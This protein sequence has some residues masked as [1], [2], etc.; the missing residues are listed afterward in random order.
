MSLWEATFLYLVRSKHS[1]VSLKIVV[2]S[3]HCR[4][5]GSYC[6]DYEFNFHNFARQ[7]PLKFVIRL[8]ITYMQQTKIT[9]LSNPSLELVV[10]GIWLCSECQPTLI[11]S[12]NIGKFTF[13]PVIQVCKNLD[14]RHMDRF[15]FINRIEIFIRHSYF[16]N[17]SKSTQ[18]SPN[19]GFWNIEIFISKSNI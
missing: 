9:S 11:I 6:D 5:K 8:V 13:G 3:E 17:V 16:A 12:A 18:M 10:N 1:I 15:N 19:F 4:E 7:R 2:K 14:I